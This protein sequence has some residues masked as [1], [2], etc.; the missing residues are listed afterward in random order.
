MSY[1][2]EPS[3]KGAAMLHQRNSQSIEIK[4]NFSIPSFRYIQARWSTTREKNVTDIAE[5]WSNEPNQVLILSD[6]K[7]GENQMVLLR[8]DMFENLV[9]LLKDVISGEVQIKTDVQ[10]MLDAIAILKNRVSEQGLDTKDQILG[11]AIQII[12]RM[13]GQV[14]SSLNFTAPFRP[15]SPGPLSEED[16]KNASELPEDEK[17]A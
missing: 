6:P 7:L 4:E 17:T 13:Q 14:N 9:K 15:V 16:L 3:Q 8:K 12:S 10:T 5:S 2:I 11:N 1:S